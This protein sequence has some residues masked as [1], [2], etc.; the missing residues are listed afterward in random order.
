MEV[1]RK[2]GHVNK[3]R[4]RTEILHGPRTSMS[5]GGVSLAIRGVQEDPGCCSDIELGF[6]HGRVSLCLF[7]SLILTTKVRITNMVDRT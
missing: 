1:I 4:G 5:G 3:D 2:S 6:G 7:L